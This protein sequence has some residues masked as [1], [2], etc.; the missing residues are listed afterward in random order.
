[1][2]GKIPLVKVQGTQNHHLFKRLDVYWVRYYKASKG[3]LEESLKT[4]FLSDARI[5]RDKRIAEFLGEKPRFAGK[6]VLLED[7]WADFIKLKE[8][9]SLGT[10]R[11]NKDSWNC[12]LKAGFGHMLLE[13][14]TPD[15][16]LMWVI[17]ERAK[18]P[19]RK[20][21]TERR[22]LQNILNWLH[23][24]GRIQRAV[25]LEHVDPEITAGK[26]YSDDQL[27][28]LLA[29]SEPKMQLMI[30]MGCE[31]MMR[32][33]EIWSLEWSQIDLNKKLIHLPAYKTK[34][35]RARTF[36]IS[37]SVLELLMDRK[38]EIISD[39]VFPALGDISRCAGKHA[40]NTAWKRVKKNS[41]VSG[42]FHDLRHTGL[43]H[44]FKKSV[45][46]ALICDFAGLSLAEAQQTYLHFTPEDTRLVAGLFEAAA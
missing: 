5:A 30:R 45:N 43:T 3:R 19:K 44:A 9:K 27:K 14:I 33:G 16:W 42:R 28:K 22:V 11:V 20:F 4:T 36:A 37:K 46:P 1:M 40:A 17:K 31:M 12:H 21:A 32:H 34:I 41:K 24:Q 10:Q 8:A 13:D 7:V 29:V 39:W 18:I 2:S 25:K 6:G 15:A 38:L 26:T 23:S 35:R